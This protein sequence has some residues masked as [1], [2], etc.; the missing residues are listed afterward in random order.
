MRSWRHADRHPPEPAPQAK[1]LWNGQVGGASATVAAKVLKTRQ[2][3]PPAPPVLEVNRAPQRDLRLLI[4]HMGLRGVERALDV[5]RTTVSRWLSGR[6]RI[7]GA[8]LLAIRSLLGDLPGT[9]RKWTGWR[10]HDGEL[11]APGGDR[12]TPGD[13][14]GIRL[15]Q[16]RVSQLDRELRDL[17]ARLKVLEK[18]VDLYGP[19]ANQEQARA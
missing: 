7:G 14:L 10:F 9:D 18:T 4:E 3:K 11:I 12:Y 8:D 13:V 1:P 5:H 6:C 17:R 19:A 16:Q 2:P 15:Q